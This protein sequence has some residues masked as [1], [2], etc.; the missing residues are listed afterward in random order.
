LANLVSAQTIP[1]ERLHFN[2]GFAQRK[3]GITPM[4]RW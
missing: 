1:N 2:G 4:S 3:L